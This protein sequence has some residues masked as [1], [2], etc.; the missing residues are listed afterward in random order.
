MYLDNDGIVEQLDIKDML[1]WRLLSSDL[2][3]KSKVQV[4]AFHAPQVVNCLRSNLMRLYFPVDLIG[5]LIMIEK[6]VLGGI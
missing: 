3:R 4:H 6:L 5:N 2:Q 1:F